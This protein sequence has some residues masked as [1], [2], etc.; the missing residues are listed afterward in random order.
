MSVYYYKIFVPY[1]VQLH[2]I[3]IRSAKHSASVPMRDDL[4][5][6]IQCNCTRML[7]EAPVLHGQNIKLLTANSGHAC[8]LLCQ[9]FTIQRCITT[10]NIICCIFKLIICRWLPIR[11]I[12]KS[13]LQ[14]MS[15]GF[16][17]FGMKIAAQQLIVSG[18]PTLWK[19]KLRKI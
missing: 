3:Y 15:H 5:Y 10:Q 2:F 11:S 9:T 14:K 4:D 17:S 16:R 19:K 8:R 18:I 13:T 7:S 1:E 12:K 6:I